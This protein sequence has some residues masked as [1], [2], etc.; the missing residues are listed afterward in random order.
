MN[1]KLSHLM[2]FRNRNVTDY[3]A[4]HLILRPK[5]VEETTKVGFYIPLTMLNSKNCPENI[6]WLL[7]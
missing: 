2:V 5:P 4:L 6:P 7:V 1:I 3:M